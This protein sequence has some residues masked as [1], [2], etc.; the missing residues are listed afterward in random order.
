M[1][2]AEFDKLVFGRRSV[3]AFTNTP[4]SRATIEKVLAAAR[5]APSGANLQPGSFVVLTGDALARFSDTLCGA[6]DGGLEVTDQYSYFPDPMP[7]YL[8]QRQVKVGAALYDSLGIDRKDESARHTQFL[9][10]YQFFGAP[11]GIVATIDRRMGKGCFMDFGMMLQTVFL[12][13]RAHGLACCGIGALAH[14]GPFIEE[15]LTLDGHD[16][17]VCGIALGVEDTSAPVNTLRTER[18]S[19]DQFVRF[20]GWSD[21]G[22][23][24]ASDGD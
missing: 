19:V 2:E 5:T 12:A 1:N 4:V 18:L 16:M 21:G 3:R 23:A 24:G 11:V 20:D 6:I 8:R 9:K 13:A 22:T 7:K 17:V 10:N 15:Y 14:F